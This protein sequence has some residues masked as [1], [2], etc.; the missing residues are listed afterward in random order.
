MK[1]RLGLDSCRFHLLRSAMDSIMKWRAHGLASRILSC[2]PSARHAKLLDIGSG[3]GH[4][5]EYLRQTGNLEVIETD[6]VDISTTGPGPQVLLGA[7]CLP[8]AS[9]VFDAV[10]LLYVLHY[11][12]APA[13]VLSEAAR[14]SRGSVLV[15]QTVH[16]GKFGRL[17]LHLNEFAFGRAA[18]GIARLFGMIASV[19]CPLRSCHNLSLADLL[20]AARM[21]GLVPERVSVERAFGILPIARATCCLSPRHHQNDQQEQM[22]G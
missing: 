4:N 22:T 15:I 21:T 19:P 5:A 13:A 9:N 20:N 1:T 10:L 6:M 3:T 16:V 14:V 2:L 18:F 17:L 12:E 11:A 7:Q 8:F